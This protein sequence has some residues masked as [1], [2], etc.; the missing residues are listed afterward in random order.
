M[1]SYGIYRDYLKKENKRVIETEKTLESF[2]KKNYRNLEKNIDS[3]IDSQLLNFANRE[4][5]TSKDAMERI[6][7]FDVEEFQKVF[8]DDMSVSDLPDKYLEQLS[9]FNV[10]MRISRLEYI[11][12]RIRLE[13]LRCANDEEKFLRDTLI[14]EAI[15]AYKDS[16]ILKPILF[17]SLN[18]YAKKI[19]NT[20]HYGAS[21]SDRVWKNQAVL[22]NMIEE[23]I[24][25]S[26]ILGQSPSKWAKDLK[27]NLKNNT[28]K[29]ATYASRRLAFSEVAFARSEASIDRF[30]KDDSVDDV[31]VIV[32]DDACNICTFHSDDVIKK[33]KCIPG[34]NVP[35]FHPFCRCFFAPF[36]NVD[37][38]LGYN[39]NIPNK[40][41]HALERRQERNIS[42]DDVLDALFNPLKVG[43][44]ILDK[45]GRPSKKYIGKKV[46]VVINPDTN[47]EIT[48]W[49][50]SSKLIRKYEKEEK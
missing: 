10:K 9:L 45:K 38:P 20:S 37:K 34:D 32:R 13:T 22:Q 7:K 11:K 1:S 30:M 2:V 29:F 19:I 8:K 50:T 46:T 47:K 4:N 42:N 6:K 41:E 16:G 12:R 5:I 40:T 39:E 14:D 15:H 36:V 26:F 44:L 49:K 27:S 18:D 25:K 31:V 48:S 17:S 23:G 35:P 3:I 33:D 28:L 43:N 24:E 21:F